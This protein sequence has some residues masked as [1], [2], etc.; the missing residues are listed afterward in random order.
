MGLQEHPVTPAERQPPVRGGVTIGVE[1]EFLLV[2]A[3]SGQLAPHA[4]AVLA[5]A[6]NGQIGR[7][8]V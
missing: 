8:H 6:A 4:E 3:A 2:D 7:A 1:E 5:E